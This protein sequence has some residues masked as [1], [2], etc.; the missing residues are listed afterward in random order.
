M[1][2]YHLFKNYRKS[3]I[4]NKGI[5]LVSSWDARSEDVKNRILHLTLIK[6]DINQQSFSKYDLSDFHTFL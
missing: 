4:P 6:K 3:E 5:L 2:V 1:P